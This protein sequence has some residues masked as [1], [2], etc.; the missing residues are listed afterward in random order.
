MTNIFSLAQKALAR[1]ASVLRSFCLC[2]AVMAAGVASAQ[3]DAADTMIL[4][5]SDGADGMRLGM[6]YDVTAQ[7]AVEFPAADLKRLRGARITALRIAIGEPLVQQSAFLFAAHSL[8]MEQE[9]LFRQPATL[10]PGWNEIRLETPIDITGEEDIFI[11]YQYTSS[12]NVLSFDGRGTNNRANWIRLLRY[13]EDPGKD[14]AWQHQDGGSHNIQAVVEGDALPQNDVSIVG[15]YVR[16]IA[17]TDAETPLY[18]TLHNDGAQTVRTLD[19]SCSIEGDDPVNI[20]AEGLDIPSGATQLVC[21]GHVKFVY[22]GL[23]DVE[24]RVTAVNG[25]TDPTPEGNELVVRNVVSRPNYVQRGVLLEHFSTV[26]CP[27]CPGG[28]RTIEGALRYAPAVSHVIHHSGFGTDKF[29]IPAS[30]SYLWL[31][32]ASSTY[33]P[34]LMLDRTNMSRHGADNGT[35]GVSP[36]GPVFY[37]RRVLLDD[38]LYEALSTPALVSIEADHSFDAARRQL[39]VE[40]KGCVPSGK[41]SD[42]GDGDVRLNIFL[43][44]DGLAFRQKGVGSS[45]GYSDYVHDAVMRKVL[46]ATWGDVVK[47]DDEGTYASKVYTTTLPADWKPENMH[48]VAFLS[49]YDKTDANN[50]PVLNTTAFDL[51]APGTLGIDAVVLDPASSA[52]AA[53]YDLSGNIV[54]SATT[55]TDGLPTGIYLVRTPAVRTHKV[56]VGM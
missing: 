5:H 28:H 14:I 25:Q 12:G 19:V 46:T 8:S 33:A 2:S 18:L 24:L 49:R 39:K 50:S 6:M 55:S 15:H 56:V 36:V 41:V 40:V 48:V 26:E 11:G 53:V 43:T 29:T 22:E 20:H 44:E 38:I 27:N 35:S 16:R 31:Y 17:Q 37:P 51:T 45:N 52:S 47:F 13:A 30:E 10:E 54:R 7:A 3:N 1:H 23:N 4:S 34:A 21:V 32:N 42:L 9:Y